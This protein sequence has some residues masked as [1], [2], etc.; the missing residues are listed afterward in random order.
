MFGYELEFWLGLVVSGVSLGGVYAL[1]G[2]GLTMVFGAARIMNFAQGELFMLGGYVAWFCSATL[3]ANFWITLIIVTLTLGMVGMLLNWALF[4]RV[5]RNPRSLEIGIVMTLGLS[6]VLQESALLLGG[7]QSRR[8]TDPLAG[9]GIDIGGVTI[10]GVRLVALGLAVVVLCSLWL[11]LRHSRIGLAILGVPAN[12][13][14]ARTLGIPE[15]RI[16]MIALALGSALSGLAAASI[17][18][19]FGVYPSM[20]AGFIYIGFAILFMGGMTSI[21]GTAIAAM[22]VGI[23]I[24]IMGGVVSAAAANVAP[25]AVVATVVLFRPHGL[26]GKESRAT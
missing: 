6:M 16:N 9:W 11:T 3:G 13:D 25:L 12:R 18:P 20:G 10:Q 1:F 22:I 8:P 19:F 15:G 23:A 26:F 17:A 2:T 21:V 4:R 5:T 24:A 14:L 7:I